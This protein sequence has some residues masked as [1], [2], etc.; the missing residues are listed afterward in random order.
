M[1][2]HKLLMP[3]LCLGLLV[4]SCSK[5]SAPAPV[6]PSTA[7]QTFSTV[8]TDVSAAITGLN[9]APGNVALNSFAGLTNTHSPFSRVRSF[10]S[11]RN[12]GEINAAISAGLA[13]IRLMLLKSTASERIAGSAPFD[14]A[15]KVGTYTW[16]KANH[17]WSKTS[18]GSIIKIDYPSDT[19]SSTNNTELQITAYTETQ[20]GTNYYP[21]DIEAAV[22]QPISGGTKQLGL[23]LSASGYDNTGSPNKAS[24][25][26]FINPYTITL[27]FD[28]SQANSTT[29]SFSFSKGSTVYIGTSTTATYA[30]ASDKT[31]GNPSKLTGYVQLE[32]TRFDANIDGTKA[33]TAAS[34]NDFITI[35]VTINGG[36]AGHVV[37]VTDPQTNHQV[38]YVQ[39]NDKTQAPLETVFADLKTQLSSLGI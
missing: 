6:S 18:G 30:S 11:L 16:S 33:A 37:W 39:Y 25:S 5:S 31:N 20:V 26:L 24:I 21:T 10:N 9:T 8:N 38:P 32:N 23:T 3:V 28:N 4:L 14:F 22:F 12:P 34:N 17:S 36:E 13:S 35:T 1:K 2:T 15:S 7:Q 29:E 27:S 19:T